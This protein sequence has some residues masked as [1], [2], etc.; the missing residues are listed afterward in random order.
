[1]LDRVELL[2]KWIYCSSVIVAALSRMSVGTSKMII[3]IF[4]IIFCA[5]FRKSTIFRIVPAPLL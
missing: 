1:M 2:I 5:I 4:L 3:V